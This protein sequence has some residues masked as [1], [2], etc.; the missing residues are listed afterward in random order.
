[1]PSALM[2]HFD[3]LRAARGMRTRFVES[4]IPETSVSGADP[5]D[6][7]NDVPDTEVRLFETAVHSQFSGKRVF[8]LWLL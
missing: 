1:M 2:L 3:A 7:D 4:D 6:A 8:S 5:D